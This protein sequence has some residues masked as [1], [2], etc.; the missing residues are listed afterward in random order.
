[1]K[2][3]EIVM[4]ITYIICFILNVYEAIV[5]KDGNRIIIS[6]WIFHSMIMFILFRQADKN[7]DKQIEWRDKLITELLKEKIDRGFRGFKNGN[8]NKIQNKQ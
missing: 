3:A 6:Y 2:I 7:C 4:Y 1:M 5:Q 8:D